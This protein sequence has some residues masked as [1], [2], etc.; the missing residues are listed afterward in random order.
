LKRKEHSRILPKNT[1]GVNKSSLTPLRIGRLI[2]QGITDKALA[3]FN[4]DGG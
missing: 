4:L 2:Q 3:S 1:I